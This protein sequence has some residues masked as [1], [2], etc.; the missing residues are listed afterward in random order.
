[1]KMMMT[2]RVTWL[3]DD[4]D[5]GIESAGGVVGATKSF[6]VETFS[7]G[8]GDL[9]VRVTNPLGTVEPVRLSVCPS[10]CP[11]VCLSV[12]LSC[13]WHRVSQNASSQF[14]LRVSVLTRDI[15]IANLS[16]RP[17][18]RLSVRYVAVS[19]E[20]GLTYRR[21]FFHRTVAQSF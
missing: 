19:D 10:V 7:A 2:S 18:V 15:D 4:A 12:C 16:V 21:S 1:M 5:V 13:C 9:Q 17:S 6:T 14:L 3:A 8:R 11:S 20:N